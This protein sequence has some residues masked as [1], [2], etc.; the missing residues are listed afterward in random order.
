MVTIR[1]P[2]CQ[3]ATIN[4]IVTWIVR[5]LY[6]LSYI[7][8]KNSAEHVHTLWY[9]LSYTVHA[10]LIS[11]HFLLQ[12]CMILD[13]LIYLHPVWY[14]EFCEPLQS[15]GM[16]L[17]QLRIISTL[18]IRLYDCFVLDKG[19]LDQWIWRITYLT[20]YTHGFAEDSRIVKG[21]CNGLFDEIHSF[22]RYMTAF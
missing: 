21:F 20:K 4:D 11:N 15:Y 1:L 17:S 14:L 5:I 13:I 10:Y 3:S 6:E 2:L 22:Y 19:E 8:N 9:V 16:T 18:I 7:Y 12:L